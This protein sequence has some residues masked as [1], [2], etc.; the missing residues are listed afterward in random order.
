MITHSPE[1]TMSVA[2]KLAKKLSK[3]DVVMLSGDLGSGKTTFTKGLGKALGVK[4]AKTRINSP[5][6]VLIKEYNGLIPM[7]HL[8]L[9]RLDNI[10]DIEDLAIGEYLYGE[11]VTIIEWAEKIKNAL[12]KRYILVRFKVKG[13]NKR[14][15]KIE[16]FRH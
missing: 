1:E 14:E 3:G 6:F 2:E 5:T 13:R 10:K 16:D 8:D 7:Y 9:Y 12:P 15:V 11:G 4:N